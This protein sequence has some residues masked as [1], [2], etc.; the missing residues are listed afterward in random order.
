MFRLSN[1]KLAAYFNMLQNSLPDFL[2][3]DVELSQHSHTA[4]INITVLID[5]IVSFC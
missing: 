4:V 2:K 5:K 3:R 1:V